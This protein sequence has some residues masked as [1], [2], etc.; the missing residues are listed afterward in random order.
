M[1]FD[2]LLFKN[3]C[4][5]TL[6]TEEQAL[7]EKGRKLLLWLGIA[8]MVMAFAGLTSGYIVR[9]GGEGWM[10]FD[11][12]RMFF[13]STAIILL[14]SVS[15]NIALSSVKKDDLKKIK[16][17]LAITL[18]LGLAFVFCQFAAWKELTSQHIFF[19][20]KDSNASGSFL[21]VL[22]G[23]HLAH[24]FGGLIVLTVTLIKV[25]QKKY[26]SENLLGLKLAAIYWHFLDV[27]W[28]YLFLFLY[29]IR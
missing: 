25:L 28:V 12:P 27:L 13:I 18:L 15:M 20:G 8:S 6:P 29:F 23:L 16:K 24:L 9:R 7:H 1:G 26:S 19:T 17:A 21:Y 4:M 10:H 2:F 5:S 11:L 14:S 3:I 22:S